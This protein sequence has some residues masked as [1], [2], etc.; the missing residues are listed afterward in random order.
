[1]V[2]NNSLKHQIQT[3]MHFH[4]PFP[5]RRKLVQFVQWLVFKRRRE[6]CTQY[7]YIILDYIGIILGGYEG[8][9]IPLIGVK[10]FSIPTFSNY[11]KERK[12]SKPV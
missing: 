6:K 12:Q 7:N 5:F 11:Q 10:G 1:V 3:K 8:R 2:E 9:Y 4:F